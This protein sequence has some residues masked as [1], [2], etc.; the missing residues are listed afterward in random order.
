MLSDPNSRLAI[1]WLCL[2]L[3]EDEGHTFCNLEE[4]LLDAYQ[5]TLRP[6]RLWHQQDHTLAFFYIQLLR[7]PKGV[8]FPLSK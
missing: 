1:H 2:P 3:K 4:M 8:V 6:H 5:K 7:S